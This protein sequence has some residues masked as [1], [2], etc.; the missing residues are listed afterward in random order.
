M[1]LL[2]GMF[3]YRT[4][5]WLEVLPF[6]R[7]SLSLGRRFLGGVAVTV[8]APVSEVSLA[9]L[10]VVLRFEFDLSGVFWPEGIL[11]L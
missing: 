10:F 11:V 1:G 3:R 2:W 6:E 8:E 4:I 7:P 5:S 9:R